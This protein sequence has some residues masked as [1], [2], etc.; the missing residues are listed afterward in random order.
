MKVW[1]SVGMRIKV[2]LRMGVRAGMRLRLR[3]RGGGGE[4]HAT[5]LSGQG[6]T[7]ATVRLLLGRSEGAQ[8]PS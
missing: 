5:R 1:V 2:G 7:V 4:V 3:L 8:T 6:T